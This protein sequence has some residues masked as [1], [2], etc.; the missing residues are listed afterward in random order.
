[1]RT[2]F[3]PILADG[4]PLAVRIGIATG[5][6]MVG[7]PIGAGAVREDSVVGE[8]LNLAARLQSLAGPNTIV[9]SRST[10]RLVGGRFELA[11][12]GV[13]D[14][15]GF[16]APVPA[17]RVLDESPTVGRFE[18]LQGGR[19]TPLVGREDELDLLLARWRD[20]K[21]GRGQ[22]VLLSGEPGSASRASRKLRQQLDA[23]SHV[24]LR[25]FCSPF[26][27]SSALHP[28]LEQVRA[29]GFE[30]DDS[31]SVRLDKLEALLGRAT[32]RPAEAA[33]LMAQALT[34]PT[35]GR[36]PPLD[37]SPQRRKEQT[38]E[39][40]GEQLDGLAARRPVLIVLEDMHWID[41]TTRE[42]L[43]LLVERLVTL[44]V[45]LVVTLRD[46]IESPWGG[47]PHVTRLPLQR[48]SLRHSAAMVEGLAPGGTISARLLEEIVGRTDG[49]P[50]FLE[51]LTKTVLESSL[52]DAADDRFGLAGSP[53]LAVPA[54]LRDSLMARLDR[55]ASVKEI[56]Q[57]GAVIGREFSLELVAAALGRPEPEIAAALDRLTASEL[58]FQ[59]GSPLA[60]S[61][62]FKHALVQDVAYQSLL[63]S[64]RQQLH[65]RVARVLVE[66]FP[67][68]AEM[69][70]E[71]LAHHFGE[72]RLPVPAIAYWR[73][74]GERAAARAANAEAVDHLASALRLL[75]ELPEA[76][77][78]REEVDLQLKLGFVLLALRGF[79]AEAVGECY[80]RALALCEELGERQK[81]LVARFGLWRFHLVRG[82]YAAADRLARELQAAA[83]QDRSAETRLISDWA[84]GVVSFWLGRLADARLHSPAR[85][86]GYRLP[87]RPR[88]ALCG[89]PRRDDPPLP[90]LGGMAGGRDGAGPGH[91]GR[92]PGAR[93]ADGPGAQPR[94]DGGP[95]GGPAPA[96][97]RCRR[98]QAVRGKRD[99]AVRGPADPPFPGAG[100][101][102]Q[103]LGAGGRRR[104]GNGGGRDGGRPGAAREA[105]QSAD[106]PLSFDPR[107]RNARE[108][109]AERRGAGA[110]RCGARR[111]R[112]QRAGLVQ[113][114]DP[115]R[116]R[117]GPRPTRPGERRRRR[118]R[119][120]ARPGDRPGTGGAGLGAAR[121]DLPGR[122]LH[123]HRPG[124]R[125]SGTPRRPAG[126]RPG[127]GTGIGDREVPDLGG[128]TNAY[129]SASETGPCATSD[130]LRPPELLGLVHPMQ[131][132]GSGCRVFR[133]TS[134]RNVAD[135]AT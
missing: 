33:A 24:C 43:D 115:S 75:P 97:G 36:Y 117:R 128:I 67:E 61:Y 35:G 71:L 40:L 26:H 57:V 120:A 107:G 91:H 109:R 42:L 112:G 46:D 4:E 23:E 95:R 93:R 132:S 51:E 124:R 77:R 99:R 41:P 106:A 129:T 5:L 15:K 114:R 34:L 27:V 2:A 111:K 127:H 25:Y 37:P 88:G 16:I 30:R 11:D 17:W 49:V 19:L 80:W 12:L 22:V 105:R 53:S 8:A 122:A 84:V 79:G 110:N 50:L 125:G 133:D 103:G 48:L 21:Q 118:G 38:F 9:I 135:S 70:P 10:R 63:K 113:R 45:L 123:A 31:D 78:P 101:G 60:R 66:R 69:A 13:H 90:V 89:E 116:A 29:A 14:L 47:Q 98:D 102:P 121:G 56:A 39:V 126:Q 130:A 28:V 52:P 131:H 96:P 74:A 65:G 94:L 76:E 6:V 82:E 108:S 55:L 86:R 64:R 85:R 72:A 134:R 62:S 7:R 81:G 83:E 32:A 3:A 58:V 18:A 100:E 44:P 1:M 68:L 92:G 119:S 104:S 54:T 73:I 87:A 20:A 59:H